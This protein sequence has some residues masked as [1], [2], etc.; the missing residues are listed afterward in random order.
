MFFW[1]KLVKVNVGYVDAQNKIEQLLR[2]FYHMTK[3]VGS[4]KFLFTVVFRL[5]MAP[6]TRLPNF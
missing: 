6:V 4:I 2:M 5:S 1:D 3:F